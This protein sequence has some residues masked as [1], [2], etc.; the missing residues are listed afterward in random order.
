MYAYIGFSPCR[1]GQIW[2]YADCE[3]ACR[4]RRQ[5]GSFGE[6]NGKPRHSCVFP[7]P[8]W[9][10]FTSH[11]CAWPNF[12]WWKRERV[13]QGLTNLHH[14]NPLHVK[15]FRRVCRLTIIIL[16]TIDEEIRRV[17]GSV[18][19]WLLLLLFYNCFLLFIIVIII[20]I[21]TTYG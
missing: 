5:N 8:P 18:Y 1:A 21:A 19:Q 12:S 15:I 20:F 11:L 2:K 4:R 13:M 14:Y 16:I 10:G 7:A 3:P 9:G 17:D 6:G